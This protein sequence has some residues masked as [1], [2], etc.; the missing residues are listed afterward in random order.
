MEN[1]DAKLH[2]HGW[3]ESEF[4]DT[5][6]IS[7]VTVE[8]DEII[9]TPRETPYLKEWAESPRKLIMAARVGSGTEIA[10]DGKGLTEL[11]DNEAWDK[12]SSDELAKLQSDWSEGL[13]IQKQPS[14][15]G[16]A[17]CFDLGREI[18]GQPEFEVVADEG[19]VDYYG[20]ECLR[21]GRPYAFKSGAEYANRWISATGAESFRTINYNGFRYLLVVMRPKRAAMKLQNLS[22]W[23]RQGELP[24]PPKYQSNDPELQRLW[25]ISIRTLQVSTQETL[26]DC[27]T[28]EQSLYVGD[29]IWNA[30]WLAKLFKEAS[31]FTHLLKSIKK[32]QHANGLFPS[33]IFASM[34]PPQYLID[35]CLIF[36]WGI[37]IYRTEIGGTDLV[38][39]LLPAA[40][41][42]LEWFQAQRSASG[43][44]ETAPK[45]MDIFPGGNI[46]IAFIDHPGIGWQQFAHP[47][48][49][50]SDRLLGLNAFLAI[51]LKAFNDSAQAVGYTPTRLDDDFLNVEK[52]RSVCKQH[53]WNEDH[54]GFADCIDIDGEL[55]GWSEQ[56]QALA[57]IAGF[58]SPDE[59]NV[60]L[61]K[62][63]AARDD[64]AVCRCTPYAWIYLAEALKISG[65]EDEI[66]PLMRSDWSKMLQHEWVTTCW[67][68]FE[69]NGGDTFCHPWSA[70]PAWILNKQ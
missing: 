31:H 18:C 19:I 70:L 32:S 66:L 7:P 44:I 25:D 5:D 65:L 29:G 27:P 35:Y 53:F 43:L 41:K 64:G 11:L 58:M 47:G 16:L 6:W 51:A 60:A 9:L 8:R 67:E 54:Q 40:E 69:G 34:E 61:S 56:S 20:A 17:L 23:R 21:N 2:P 50:R 26:V 12:L 36:I 62:I 55:R 22:V 30:L 4:N 15:E 33:A 38:K 46:K 37:D 57:T 28:R 63:L 59:A 42:T 3:K 52:L 49:E 10:S 13:G 39:E 45:Q 68:S 48:I 1:F 14:N 24:K